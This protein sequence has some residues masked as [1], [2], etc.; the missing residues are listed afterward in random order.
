MAKTLILE[1]DEYEHIITT[2]EGARE[3]FQELE[4]EVEWFVSLTTDRLLDCLQIIRKA[5]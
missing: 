3:E 1:N 5:K 2:L 4:E